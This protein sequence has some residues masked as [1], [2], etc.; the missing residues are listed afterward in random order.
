MKRYFRVFLG[1][2]SDHLDECVRGGFIGVDYAFS[3]SLAPYLE[4]TWAESR[5]KIKPIYLASNP[6][7]SP[8]GAGL[9][10]GALWTLG[11]G[12]QRGDVI[13]CPDGNGNYFSC[14]IAGEYK[15]VES[16]SLPHQR[17]VIWHKSTFLKTEMS[18]DLKIAAGKPL[19]VIE[20]SKY[21]AELDVLLGNSSGQTLF[22]IDETV[23]DPSAFA[24]EKHL[25]DFLIFN[26]SQ[27]ELAKKYDLVTD[28]GEVVAQQ[29]QS[30]TGPIDILA[31]SKDKKEYLVVEL[32]K[33]RTS[34]VVVGQT[35]RYMGFVKNELAV[36]GESVRGVIIA[37][38]DDLRLRNALSMVPAI[39]FFRYKIDFK[40]NPVVTG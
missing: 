25:E 32:K 40:L 36:N 12:M 30:D 38:E 5:G 7:K 24:L 19:T 28:E 8:V 4:D 18:A 6:G 2:G 16:G 33:G 17:D 11:K 15:Y 14:E 35:L 26:W 13:I 23:E 21:A 37:L 31:I 27:T 34:D 39:D 1:S 29:Y 10:C 20:I 3:E 22:S 9:S